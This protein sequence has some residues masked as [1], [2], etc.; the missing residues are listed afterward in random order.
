MKKL[1]GKQPLFLGRRKLNGAGQ[2]PRGLEIS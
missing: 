2:K 1:E